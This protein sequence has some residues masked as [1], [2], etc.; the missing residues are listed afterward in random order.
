MK[1]N[2]LAALL[3][4]AVMACSMTACGGD[5]SWTHRSG[6]YTVTSGMYVG[7]SIDAANAASSTEGYD[8]TKS[9][10]EQ[11]IEGS[12][13]TKWIQ[14]KA[15]E[16]AKEYLAVETQ[17]AE[18]GL[19]LSEEDQTNIDYQVEMYWSAFG[20]GTI[21]EEEGCGKTSFTNILTNSYKRSLLFEAIYGEGGE[22]EVPESE[23][24]AAFEK[25]YA[26]GIAITLSALDEEGNKLTD[27]ALQSVRD[28]A[29]KLA[30]RI[31]AGEDFETV[32]AEY[33][34]DP[35][36]EEDSSEESTDTS[37]VFLRAD[38]TTQPY[39]GILEGEIGKASVVEDDQNIYVVQPL[40]VLSGDSFTNY[41]STILQ[42]LKGEEF[43]EMVTEWAN[44]LSIEEN[45]AA[46]SKHNPKHLKNLYQ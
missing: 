9:P 39:T 20:M 7:L 25:D 38:A 19:T 4:S 46:V 12:D 14:A 34:A 29:Q 1:M 31:N 24:K 41:R 43:N 2:K 11:N 22:K 10:F 30:D 40:D 3:L 21:Y 36:A 5:T 28:D 42:N 27:D 35:E 8:A 33:L 17:F 13:G 6:D 37:V 16:L 26:K 45:S 18:R 23:L 32:K 15:N 44:A